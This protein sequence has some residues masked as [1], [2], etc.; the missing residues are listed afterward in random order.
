MHLLTAIL[1]EREIYKFGPPV[2][3][4]NFDSISFLFQFWFLFEMSVTFLGPQS[5]QNDIFGTKIEKK[6]LLYSMTKYSHFDWNRTRSVKKSQ[7][8]TKM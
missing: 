5:K 8:R 6:K 3:F 2:R 4:Q 1:F 7:I